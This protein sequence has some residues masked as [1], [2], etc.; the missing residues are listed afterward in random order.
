MKKL[1]IFSILAFVVIF[2]ISGAPNKEL[3]IKIIDFETSEPIENAR[4]LAA[5][6]GI[7]FIAYRPVWGQYYSYASETNSDGIVYVRGLTRDSVFIRVD[8]DGYNSSTEFHAHDKIIIL[9]LKK[10]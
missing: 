7:G 4:I 2:I 6:S 9:K 5:Q 3:E 8:Y 10:K 1:I